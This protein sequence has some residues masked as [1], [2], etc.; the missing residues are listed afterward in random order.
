MLVTVDDAYMPLTLTA[1]G[2]T[3]E[4]FEEFC[5]KYEDYRVEYTSEGDLLVMPPT[6]P[7][8]S[9]RNLQIAA[10]LMMW[11]LSNNKDG[12]ATESSGGFTLPSGAR[13]SPDASWIS[14]D[15]LRQKPMCPEFVIELLSPTDRPKT[16]HRKMEE[17]IANGALL[18]WLID[19][20][21]QSVSI[22][23]PGQ[24]PE[25]LTGILQLPGEGPVEGFVLELE[26][27]WRP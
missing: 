17:W 1:P 3:D 16:A 26:R 2:I 14:R 8:T 23:R 24:E 22:Y 11:A 4:Q 15:R 9:S 27:I 13:L 6:D 20:K 12:L 19:P 25:T 21:K 18:G 10:Q 7:E 5:A